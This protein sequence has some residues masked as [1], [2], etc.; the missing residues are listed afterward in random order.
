M[1]KVL[2]LTPAIRRAVADELLRREFVAFVRRTFETVVPGEELH[3]NWHIR[4]MAHVLER[5]RQGK[6]KRLI[7]TVPPRHLK[8]ITTS[9]AF[10]AFVLGHDPTK[11]CVC[12]SYSG[13]LAVKQAGRPAAGAPSGDDARLLRTR[14]GFMRPRGAFTS[15]VRSCLSIRPSIHWWDT[16]RVPWPYFSATSNSPVARSSV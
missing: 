5:V 9:V 14:I 3:L 16:W 15:I 4:A 1:P 8:S 13:D 12:L 6:I 10:P 11:K 7:I 2:R